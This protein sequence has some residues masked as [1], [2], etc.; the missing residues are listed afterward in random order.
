MAAKISSVSSN[1]IWSIDVHYLAYFP[2]AS[3]YL[4]YGAHWHV[5]HYGGM[6]QNLPM[7]YGFVVVHEGKFDIKTYK[8]K[9]VNRIHVASDQIWRLRETQEPVP[10]LYALCVGGREAYKRSGGAHAPAR[11]V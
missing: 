8:G 4:R 11:A 7:D 3:E 5:V 1:L 10:R 9:V 6:R 2:N